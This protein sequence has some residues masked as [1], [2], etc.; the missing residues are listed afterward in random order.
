MRAIFYFMMKNPSVMEKAQAE[1]DAAFEKGTLRSPVQYSQ[2]IT[3]PYLNAVIKES[4][5]LFP[6]F[7]L[8]MPR[9][10]P[11]G[12]L[13][14]G[15]MHV[16]QGYRVGMN[17]G[18]VHYNKEV[19]GSDASEFNPERWLESEERNRA[20]DKATITFGAGTRTCIGKNVRFLRGQPKDGHEAHPSRSP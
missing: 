11:L 16:P 2:A 7:Q 12:G 5:R 10:A 1:V 14:L 3:L 6:S 4:M 17:A 9:V 15:G 8:P 19:F 20:M 13:E 18:V